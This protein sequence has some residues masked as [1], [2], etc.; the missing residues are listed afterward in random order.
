[1]HR[2]WAICGLVAMGACGDSTSDASPACADPV[3]VRV[4][5]RAKVTESTCDA[6]PEGSDTGSGA[7]GFR[8]ACF[9][10]VLG[11]PDLANPM[12]VQEH[13]CDIRCFT[14]AEGDIWA[15]R[16]GLVRCTV[17]GC[18]YDCTY[19]LTISGTSQPWNGKR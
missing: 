15:F 14:S 5:S 11:H 2:V 12:L 4:T 10:G 18:R 19:T 7:I 13:G 17:S 8:D 1:M 9:P 6:Y 3:T 16:N